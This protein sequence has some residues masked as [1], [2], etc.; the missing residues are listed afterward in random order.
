MTC[1]MAFLLASVAREIIRSTVRPEFTD[2]ALLSAEAAYK[3]VFEEASE[4]EQPADMLAVYRGAS[5]QEVSQE[6]S[7]GYAA[8]GDFLPVTLPVFVRRIRGDPRTTSEIQ[9]LVEER[10]EVLR[11]AFK[12]LLGSAAR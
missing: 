7:S 6:A 2:R 11:T 9:P 4:E 5:L 1:E 8:G 10:R 3:K 12:T